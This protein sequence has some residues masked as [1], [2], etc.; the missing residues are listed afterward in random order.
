MPISKTKIIILVFGLAL[1]LSTLVAFLVTRNESNSVHDGMRAHQEG[2][3]PEGSDTNEMQEASTSQPPLEDTVFVSSN[4]YDAVE[5]WQNGAKNSGLSIEKFLLATNPAAIESWTAEATAYVD[6]F[7][8]LEA[9]SPNNFNEWQLEHL[10][11]NLQLDNYVETNFPH[12]YFSWKDSKHAPSKDVCLFGFLYDKFNGDEAILAE[13]QA[14]YSDLTNSEYKL[15]D[16]CDPSTKRRL[17]LATSGLVLEDGNSNLKDSD[18]NDFIIKSPTF[19]PP[20]T[21]VAPTPSPPTST[22]TCKHVVSFPDTPS[23][24][25]KTTDPVVESDS[26]DKKDQWWDE[27]WKA[28]HYGELYAHVLKESHLTSFDIANIRNQGNFGGIRYKLQCLNSALLE[29]GLCHARLDEYAHYASNIQTHVDGKG[30]LFR[31]FEG[32]VSAGD[33]AKLVTTIQN[34]EVPQFEKA[35]MITMDAKSEYD[36]EKVLGVIKGIIGL[37]TEVVKA[38]A[39]APPDPVKI[40]KWTTETVKNLFGIVK[41]EGTVGTKSHSVRVTYDSVSNAVDPSHSIRSNVDYTMKLTT[42]GSIIFEGRGSWAK[43][44]NSY[45]GSAFAVALTVKQIVCE[46]GVQ[47]IPKPLGAWSYAKTFRSPY[48]STATLQSN[49]RDFLQT[50]FGTTSGLNTSPHE[51]IWNHP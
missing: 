27:E 8:D 28:A 10:P 25:Q 22:C 24:F 15:E 44:N 23:T 17:R 51:G 18:L 41:Y 7:P 16:I 49:V 3:L 37:G 13:A 1:G 9:I 39:G 11:A 42:A 5:E 26:A 31:K 4:L 36:G 38:V 20:P 29:C 40:T 33:G 46:P 35:G 45:Y 21:P 6:T 19:V 43:T 50:S 47:T 32:K 34:G 2:E 48:T 12:D 30:A 14:Y